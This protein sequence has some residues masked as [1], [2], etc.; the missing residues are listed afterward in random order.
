[1]KRFPF[2]LIELTHT[3]TK[4]SPCWED[5]CGF[6]HET[7]LDY[8]DN[9]TEVTFKVQVLKMHAGIGTHM[10]A[11]AHC[12]PNGKT[13]DA[14]QLNEL[15]A[16]CVVIDVSAIAYETFLLSVN[17][18]I[19]FENNHGLIAKGTFVI[20]YTGWSLY[21]PT[22]QQ[23]RND[24]RFP[25]IS[26]EAAMLLL[27]RKIVGLG[28]DTLSPDTADS[29]YPVHQAMLGAG[30]YLIENIANANAMPTLGG[31][32]LALPMRIKDITEAP[33]RLIGLVNPS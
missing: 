27:Q 30:K 15:L 3:L 5:G 8:S 17:D 22:A 33:I 1:M 26:K 20:V 24:L 14:F 2:K 13:I 23:Y 28:I 10:D 21:W 4:D 6:E 18:I 11:P 7:R 29:G 9:T 12:I 16:P 19:R 25:S 31:F 32:T